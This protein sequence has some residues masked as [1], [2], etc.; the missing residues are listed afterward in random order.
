MNKK[1][2]VNLL[3]NP[4]KNADT[5]DMVAVRERFLPTGHYK[6]LAEAAAQRMQSEA[7]CKV[8]AGTAYLPVAGGFGFPRRPSN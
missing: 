2:Y 8:G 4:P 7:I 5:P 3:G 6:F 1:G